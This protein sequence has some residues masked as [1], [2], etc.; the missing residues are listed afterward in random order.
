MKQITIC[1]ALMTILFA[2]KKSEMT[3]QQNEISSTAVNKKPTPPP[4]NANPAIAYKGQF[5][6]KPNLTV[7]ALFVMDANGDNKT[8]IYSNYS[9]RSVNRPDFPAWSPDG[10]KLCFTLNETDLY[11]LSISLSN[12]TPTGSNATKIGDGVAGGGNYRKG[13]WNPTAN[14]IASVWLQN[15][16]PTTIRIIPAVGGAP[17]TL[18]ASSSTDFIIGDHLSFSPDGSKLVFVERQQSTGNN[19]MKIIERSTG[20]ILREIDLSQ[21]LRI[22]GID[23]ANTSGSNIVA[24]TEWPL[25]S[26]DNNGFRKLYSIDVAASSPT[27]VLLSNNER[28]GV[29]WA[30]DDLKVA[31]MGGGGLSSFCNPSTNCCGRNYYGIHTFTLSTQSSV[32]INME[33]SAVNPDWKR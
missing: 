2:C 32:T 6:P 5:V 33:F 22:T 7:P 26:V 20:N 14:E 8:N 16:K 25:C 10:T 9:A 11:T 21:F 3:V 23:W 17:V 29:T 19:I 13:V 4:G 27:P 18:Y 1:I 31:C 24:F 15:N 12:G 30:P 28:D